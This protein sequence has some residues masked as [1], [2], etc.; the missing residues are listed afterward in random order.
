MQPQKS[1]TGSCIGLKTQKH[2]VRASTF[3]S[4]G[5][6]DGNEATEQDAD[7]AVRDIWIDKSTRAA[8]PRPLEIDADKAAFFFP[9]GLQGLNLNE[10]TRRPQRLS[11]PHQTPPGSGPFPGPISL[12]QAWPTFPPAS[13]ARPWHALKF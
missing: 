8:R 3:P 1:Q 7:D 12:E 6:D 10:A 9:C 4:S 5:R 13:L 11:R 2:A